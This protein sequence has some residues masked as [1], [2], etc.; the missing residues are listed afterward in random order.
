MCDLPGGNKSEQTAS[1]CSALTLHVK[2]PHIQHQQQQRLSSHSSLSF[3]FTCCSLFYSSS[4]LCFYVSFLSIFHQPL[5][6]S[7]LHI[8]PSVLLSLFRDL[9]ARNCLVAEQNVVKIS[10]FGMSRQQ[11][12]G[13]YSA[14]G[15]KQIPV[16]WTAPE[17]LNYGMSPSNC[18][19][20]AVTTLCLPVCIHP[21]F[22]VN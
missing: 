17:A 19:C 3:L 15:L 20:P 10:D 14:E 5:Y 21:E 1:S 4:A 16:K 18:L 11:D 2:L 13:V 8:S 22:L 7:I 9:A 6:T 12:D